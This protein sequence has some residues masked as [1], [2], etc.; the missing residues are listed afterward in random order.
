MNNY[1]QSST[2]INIILERMRQHGNQPA[3]FWK[4]K[5]Y[6]Y[7]QLNVMI[8]NWQDRLENEFNIKKREVCGILGDFSPEAI[9]L[10]YALM[11][12][13]C[14]IVPFTKQISSQ[15]EEF[16]EIS[17]V[18]CIFTMEDDDGWSFERYQEVPQAALIRQFRKDRDAPGLVVFTS[19]STGKPKGI[20]QDCER[21]MKKFVV[22]RKG[23]RMILFLMFDHFG[24]INTMFSAF[25]YGGV[26]V[27]ISDRSCEEVGK[28]IERSKATLLPTTPTFLN[29]L[30]IS[31]IYRQ[32]DLS[33]IELITYGTEVMPESLLQ[34]IGEVFPN[35]KLKQTYGLSELGVLRSKSLSDDSPW[36]KIGG[37][38]F[39][40]K[41]IDKILWVKSES[42]MVGYL[43][44][45][46]P[47]DDEGWM[48]TGDQVEIGGDYLKILGRK[49]EMINVGGQKVFPQEV[50]AVIAEANNITNVTVFGVPHPLMGQ[51]VHA[52]VSLNKLETR[53]ELSERLRKFCQKRLT[54]YKIPV[55]F[56]IVSDET[57]RSARYK[58]VRVNP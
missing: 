50:E 53:R 18:Q 32:F 30:I 20:L 57:Q 23:W 9:A 10:F 5:E 44:A 12:K 7:S 38:G 24:G 51:L 37:Q 13:K 45:P 54:K 42:A 46:S 1:K 6:T 36:V 28:M 29:L 55:R 31:G 14:I 26:A 40:I 11:L 25:A 21:V 19:G 39:D 34:K 52:K 43:N 41:V 8:K 15:V 22:E 47:Y 3:I 48:C 35:A 16:K 33:S 17:G 58:K 2:A 27:C 49:S 56:I 4:D